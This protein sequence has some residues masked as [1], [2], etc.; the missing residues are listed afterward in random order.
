[1]YVL[2]SFDDVDGVTRDAVRVA[3]EEQLANVAVFVVTTSA[4]GVRE[5]IELTPTKVFVDYEVTR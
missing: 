3:L 2:M 5:E 1:M 4:V